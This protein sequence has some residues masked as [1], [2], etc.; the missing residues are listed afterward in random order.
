MKRLFFVLSLAL[1]VSAEELPP[2]PQILAAARAQLPPFPVY[3]SG[4]LKQ[5]APNGFVRKKLDVEMNLDWNATAP[6]AVYKITDSKA[7]TFQTLELTL[8]SGAMTSVFAE[9]GKERL[10]DPHEEVADCGV[11]WAD[12]TFAFLWNPDAKTV[13][14]DKKFGKERYEI[15]IPRPGGRILQ[16]WVEKDTGRMVQAEERDAGGT[17]RK[18]I[19]VVSVKNFDD[20]WMVK[21]LDIIQPETGARASLRIDEVKKAR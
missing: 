4:T 8:S 1:S 13:G 7:G 11:T 15:A 2:A 21:D 10:F 18:V 17:R 14:V 5:K 6:G 16:L 9:N 3:M 12:L 20:L 19:K